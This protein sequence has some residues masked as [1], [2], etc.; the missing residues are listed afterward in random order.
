MKERNM[1]LRKDDHKHHH[2]YFDFVFVE[3]SN[4]CTWGDYGIT[5]SRNIYK[6]EELDQ[7]RGFDD[8]IS[9]YF[10]SHS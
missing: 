10:L 6:S 3:C 4:L 7:L 8:L 2:M 1:D 5:K 9:I